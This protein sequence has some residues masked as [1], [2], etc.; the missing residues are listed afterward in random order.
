MGQGCQT[1]F[2]RS[3]RPAFES[4]P[5]FTHWVVFLG[6]AA[7]GKQPKPLKIYFKCIAP[8]SKNSLVA[9]N[10]A[11]LILPINLET[12]TPPAAP[13]LLPAAN[14]S[15]LSLAT[16]NIELINQDLDTVLGSQLHS[17]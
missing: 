11:M 1:P 15:S 13:N 16:P 6:L 2:L 14:R 8:S 10:S 12:W 4:S 9:E 17:Q 7:P 5:D 3:L